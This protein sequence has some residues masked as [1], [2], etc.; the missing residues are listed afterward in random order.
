MIPF[1]LGL[2]GIILVLVDLLNHNAKAETFFD[3]IRDPWMVSLTKWS[4]LLFLGLIGIG[5]LFVVSAQA[6]GWFSGSQEI[7]WT[8]EDWLIAAMS[9]SMPPLISITGTLWMLAALDAFPKGSVGG[10]GLLSSTISLMY[11]WPF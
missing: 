7:A 10:V 3:H 6:F 2:I 1:A 4:W 11:D 9:W 5:S 8:L